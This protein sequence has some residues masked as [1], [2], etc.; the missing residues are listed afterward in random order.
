MKKRFISVLVFAML[1]SAGAAF[2]LYR[3]I[4]SKV[5]AD[6]A[7]HPTTT[8]VFVAAKDLEPGAL[9][10]EKDVLTQQ[11]VS[12]PPGV[13]KKKEDI[14]NRGV[15]EVIHRDAPF[16]EG[17]LA[18]PGA[19]AGFANTIPKGMRALAVRVN[20][21]VGLAGFTVAGMHVDIL[22]EGVPPG[23]TLGP[24][25]RTLLQNITVLSAGQNYQKDVEGKPVMVP[26]VNLLVTPEQAE[27]LN[28]AANERIQLV[29]RNPTDLEVTKT[30]GAATAN[31]F[32]AGVI[33]KAPTSLPSSPARPKRTSTPPLAAAF[34]PAPPAGPVTPPR[35]STIE[36][37]SGG[38]RVEIL[39]PTR[40]AERPAIA[41]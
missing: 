37:L 29:L 22:V 27:I 12:V 26:V 11:Y 30:P 39:V 21:V 2:V 8:A 16:F 25:S 31:L 4:S 41:Q 38:S 18:A 14:L 7:S 6:A 35:P 40:I 33:A 13:I 24:V 32:A 5:T 28:L 20:E 17:T 1:V 23:G 36:V 15:V 3:L 19:G 34:V 10:T 9:V